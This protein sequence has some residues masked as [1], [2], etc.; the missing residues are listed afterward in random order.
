[1]PEA[2]VDENRLKPTLPAPRSSPRP[3]APRRQIARPSPTQTNSAYWAPKLAKNKERDARAIRELADM[4][5]RT[6]VLWQCQLGDRVGVERS[7]RDFLGPPLKQ[8][9]PPCRKRLR[10]AA[11]SA[12][13]R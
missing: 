3:S 11:N 8:I 9:D 5:W 2:A 1:M 4:G 6:L 10:K 13:I 12:A 7:L